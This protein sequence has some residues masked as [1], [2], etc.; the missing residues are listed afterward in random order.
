MQPCDIA[1]TV[2][3]LTGQEVVVRQRRVPL[4][5]ID[6]RRNIVDQRA[7]G[8]FPVE[9]GDL[10]VLGIGVVVALLGAAKLVA[11]LQQRQAAGQ[12]QGGQHRPDVAMA[13]GVHRLVVG[14]PFRPTVP[15][16][17]VVVAVA[18]VLAVGV[19]V[20]V[21]IADEIE[22]RKAI[23]D[24]EHVDASRRLAAGEVEDFSRAGHLAGQRTDLAVAALPERA[25]LVAVGVVVLVE[26]L[27][28]A[29]ELVAART[30]VPG[31]GDEY[32]L[33]QHG[34]GLDH[35]QHLGIG[36]E[37][38]LT[39]Q[40][41]SEVEAEA[42]DAHL[43][44]P[45]TQAVDHQPLC[46]GV[47]AAQGVAGAGVVDEVLL[48]VGLDEAVIGMGVEAHHRQHRALRV[49]FAGVVV[50]HVEDH[51]DARLAVGIGHVAQ[52]LRTTGREPRIDGEVGD[53][54]VAPG[55]GQAQRRQ[56]AFVDPGRGR[57]QLHRIDAEI[58]EVLDDAPRREAG[59]GAA[60]RSLH[61][62]VAHGKAA[63]VQLIEH[64]RRAAARH[65]RLVGRADDNRLGDQR[66]GVDRLVA[67]QPQH[68]RAHEHAVEAL[69]VRVDQQ[70]VRV[71]KIPLVGVVAAI[72]AEAVAGPCP[73]PGDKPVMDVVGMAIEL[74]PGNLGFDFVV[75]GDPDGRGGLGIDGEV[76]TIGGDGGAELFGRATTGHE[77]RS[78]ECRILK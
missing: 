49:A 75:D 52:F 63:N 66:G 19:V 37:A 64:P 26:L 59:D 22:E 53:G 40:N 31:L 55:V 9:P 27:A 47:V 39:S 77:L 45:V 17:V 20:L 10:V 50:D 73:D 76:H 46:R 35:L 57:H 74:D 65:D 24:G 70:L 13:H 60:Q 34:V 43:L 44:D 14:R 29:A 42:G 54:V 30:R 51:R 61:R 7:I 78:H 33:A 69:R 5:E 58:L 62:R 71:E 72:G 32:R 16:V 68:R 6:Q 4:P 23:V 48:S 25:D 1:H 8:L 28:E 18:V 15:R 11:L 3:R 56:V 36:V 2:L 67:V 12:E 38:R 21:E 41:R